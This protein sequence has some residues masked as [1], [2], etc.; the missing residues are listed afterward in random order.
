MKPSSPSFLVDTRSLSRDQ[1][2]ILLALIIGTAG[3]L[4]VFLTPDPLG[5]LA[6][7]LPMLTPR[8]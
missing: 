3:Q 7:Q 8:D 2:G 6:P 4:I 5:I 1:L